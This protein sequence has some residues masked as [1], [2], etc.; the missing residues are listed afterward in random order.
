M[1]NKQ[2]LAELICAWPFRAA[3][4][5]YLLC[6]LVFRGMVTRGGCNAKVYVNLDTC[7]HRGNQAA[8]LPVGAA[9]DTTIRLPPKVENNLTDD[10]QRC[11]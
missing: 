8:Q 7:G 5:F 1:E 11:S 10:L 3:P 4:G 6:W 9:N 2:I